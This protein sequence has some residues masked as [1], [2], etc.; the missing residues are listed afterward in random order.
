MKSALSYATITPNTGSKTCMKAPSA[1]PV[2]VTAEDKLSI[3]RVAGQTLVCKHLN[4]G[5]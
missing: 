5:N 2:I 3:S 4:L 1:S